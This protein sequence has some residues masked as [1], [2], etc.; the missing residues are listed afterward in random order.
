VGGSLLTFVMTRVLPGDPAYLVAGSFAD[1]STIALTRKQLGLSRPLWEQYIIYMRSLLHGDLGTSFSTSQ[2]VLLDLAQRF[3]ATLELTFTALIVS[4]MIAVPLGIA[5]ARRPKSVVAGFANLL[6]AAGSAVPVFWLGL[7]L[8]YLLFY[9]GGLFPAPLGRFPGGDAPYQIT[10]FLLVDTLISGDLGA[11]AKSL[12][13]LALPA[14]TLAAHAQPP[15]LRLTR[16][17]IGK[18]LE[19]DAVRSAR[20]AGLPVRTVI[21]HDALRLALL[22]LVHLTVLTFGSLLSGSVLVETVFSWPGIG[23]YSVQAIKASDYPAIQGVVLL[24]ALTYV[25]AYYIVDFAEIAIDPRL[26][27]R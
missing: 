16:V 2:P 24:M 25:I 13:S 8:I 7:I 22:P 27:V 23:Q 1:E 15:L 3:P 9:L 12:W 11:F 17:Q 26:R 14:F 19:S 21:Y 10:G 18:A 20:A 5:A 6:A 4:L